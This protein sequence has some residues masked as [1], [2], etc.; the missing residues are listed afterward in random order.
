MTNN[1]ESE[2]WAEER[3]RLE[4]WRRCLREISPAHCPPLGLVCTCKDCI[5]PAKLKR[6]EGLPVAAADHVLAG[7]YF[8]AAGAFKRD[9]SPVGG[10]G[11]AR[12]YQDEARFFFVKLAEALIDSVMSDDDT[13]SVLRDIWFVEPGYWH[14]RLLATGFLETLDDSQREGLRRFFGDLCRIAHARQSARLWDCLEHMAVFSDALPE[15]ANE[16]RAQPVLGQIMFWGAIMRDNLHTPAGEAGTLSIDL[17]KKA[18]LMLPEDTAPLIEA[19]CN[20]V[21]G[22]CLRLA[23]LRLRGEKERDIALRALTLWE[24]SVAEMQLPYTP[25]NR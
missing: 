21:L 6:I 12:D 17:R 1:A 14:E 24:N 19:F 25:R 20:P 10:A 5:D 3:A 8:G 13:S 9:G 23:A 4:D 18:Q 7:A 15:F 16:L 11:E 2:P 22:R